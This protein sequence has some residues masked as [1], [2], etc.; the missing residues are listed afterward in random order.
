M[1]VSTLEKLCLPR[2]VGLNTREAVFTAV[3]SVV[4]LCLPRYVRLDT[5]VCVCLQVQDVFDESPFYV[6]VDSVSVMNGTDE[7]LSANFCT[8]NLI[9]PKIKQYII[10]FMQKI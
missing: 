3:C 5:V 4:K 6:P 9:H 10:I 8:N 7:G 2:Y 1:F